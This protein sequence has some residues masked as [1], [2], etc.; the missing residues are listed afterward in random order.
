MAASYPAALWT[1]TIKTD[2]VDLVL[3]EHMNRAQEEIVAVQTE[4]GI[5]VAGSVTNL[6]TRLLPQLHADGG[7]NRG[8]S[9]PGSPT[10]YQTFFRSDSNTFYVYK[11]GTWYSAQSLSNLLFCWIGHVDSHLYY[12]TN[13][14]PAEADGTRG[15]SI[16]FI[17]SSTTYQRVLQGKFIKFSGVNTVTVKAGVWRNPSTSGAIQVDIGGQLGSAAITNNTVNTEVS[18]TIDVS[19]LSNGTAY[20]NVISLK[21]DSG[22]T[23]ARQYLG[24]IMMFGS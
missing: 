16:L 10:D 5:D 13:T 11:S 12:G 17:Q 1:P 21:N 24:W 8:T 6:L 4:L 23:G 2:K 14:V 7:L 20:D 22:G 3:A 15:N 9:F 19:G 18:F